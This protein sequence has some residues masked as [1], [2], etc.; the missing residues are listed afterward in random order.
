VDP[1]AI[2]QDGRN[3]LHLSVL[4]LAAHDTVNDSTTAAEAAFHQ[5]CRMCFICS[6][7]ASCL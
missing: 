3:A 1:D 4:M 2:D 6:L 7:L 5:V